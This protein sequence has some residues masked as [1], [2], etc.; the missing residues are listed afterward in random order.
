MHGW[1]LIL[2][3]T[4]RGEVSRIVAL[5]TTGVSKEAEWTSINIFKSDRIAANDGVLFPFHSLLFPFPFLPSFYFLFLLPSPFFPFL[6][7]SSG[8]S[9]IARALANEHIANPKLFSLHQK[10]GLLQ[11]AGL[12]FTNARALHFSFNKKQDCPQRMHVLPFYLRG[13]RADLIGSAKT[14]TGGVFIGRHFRH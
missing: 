3:I 14:L 4:A 9:L 8:R 5:P 12:S 13:A 2:G 10:K 1:S 7:D 6:L 11:V